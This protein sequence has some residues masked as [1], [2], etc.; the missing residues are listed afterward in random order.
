MSLSRRQLFAR[1]SAVALAPLAKW[2]PKEEATLYKSTIRSAEIIPYHWILR[3]D[4]LWWCPQ[5]D[6]LYE[7]YGDWQYRPVPQEEA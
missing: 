5:N 4:G 7:L 1:L 3:T 2:L 6:R